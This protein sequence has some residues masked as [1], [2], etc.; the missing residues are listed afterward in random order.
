MA[1]LTIAHLTLYD[2]RR[3]RIVAA[4]T[5][6]GAVFLLVYSVAMWFAAAELQREG[7]PFWERQATLAVFTVMGLYAVNLLTALFAMLLPVDALSGEIDSGV[8]Q[9]LAVK[10]IRRADIVLGKALGY[11]VIVCIYLL[12]MAGGVLIASRVFTGYVQINLPQALMLMGLEMILLMLISIA[13]GTRMTTVTNGIVTLAFFG[14]AFVGGW[15]EQIAGAANIEAARN[16]GI[17]VSLVSPADTLWRLASNYL[18][19]EFARSFGPLVLF[20]GSVPNMLMVWWALGFI[21]VTLLWAIKS[22]N[23]RPL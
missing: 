18:Q 8:M 2:A 4:A 1:I 13:G 5:I 6:C 22:F 10:P 3:K 21:V 20:T 19:P 9:T 7:G 12:L 17:F 14:M 16:V 23:Q 15:I 11:G